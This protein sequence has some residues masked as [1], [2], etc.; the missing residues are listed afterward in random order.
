MRD[1]LSN[2]GHGHV[3]VFQQ[4][5]TEPQDV[6]RAVVEVAFHKQD[7][8]LGNEE[9]IDRQRRLEGNGDLS[10]GIFQVPLS[11]FDLQQH[12]QQEEC[13]VLRL[14]EQR[15][16]GGELVL[17]G[18]AGQI[19]RPEEFV[20]QQPLVNERVALSEHVGLQGGR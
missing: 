5:L 12:P 19:L 8:L 13:L 9:A 20:A 14:A 3:A 6:K 18:I 16:D 11:F 17:G 1:L 7:A 15:F 10:R 2:R 4:W